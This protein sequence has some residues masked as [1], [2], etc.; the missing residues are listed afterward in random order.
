MGNEYFCP[1]CKGK[2]KVGGYIIL[3]SRRQNGETGLMLMSPK[4]GDYK[5]VKHPDYKYSMDERLEFYCPLCGKSL[6]VPEV[7]KNLAKILMQDEN[8]QQAEIYFSEIVGEK[9]T[10]KV[11]DE[12]IESFGEQPELYTNFFGETPKY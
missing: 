11:T 7:S 6:S 9:C 4:I 5:I 8:G 10:Y 1:R 3:S 12:E 2:L